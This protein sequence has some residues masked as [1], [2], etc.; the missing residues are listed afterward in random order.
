MLVE[1]QVVSFTLKATKYYLRVEKREFTHFDSILKG[2]QKRPYW[3]SFFLKT[4]LSLFTYSVCDD[5]VKNHP[6][7]IYNYQE[8]FGLKLEFRG[9]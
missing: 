7:F 3:P 8:L 4:I 2:A 6:Y 1:L 5:K 9:T